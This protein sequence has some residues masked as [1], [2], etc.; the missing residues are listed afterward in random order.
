MLQAERA[1]QGRCEAMQQLEAAAA[2]R[3]ELARTQ[4]QL[5]DSDGL[6]RQQAALINQLEQQ[7]LAQDALPPAP[8]AAAQQARLQH[9]EAENASLRAG[10]AHA[11]AVGLGGGGGGDGDSSDHQ[12]SAE[13][14]SKLARLQSA[15][16]LKEGQHERQLRALK[17]EHERLRVEQGIRYGRP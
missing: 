8:L 12:R 4:Q 6:V 5:A 3:A 2:D 16:Q 7:L 11:Q 15:L 13:L 10:L 1:E 17:R 9:L 14:Q